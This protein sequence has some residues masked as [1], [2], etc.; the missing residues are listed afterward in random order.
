[1]RWPPPAKQGEV[2][3]HFFD[4]FTLA[5][6]ALGVAY[7]W[8]GFGFGLALL[9]GILWEAAENPIKAYLPKLFPHAT[10][11]TMANMTGDV[12]AVGCGWFVWTL[13]R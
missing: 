12:M 9:L 2:N 4:R 5:H 6:L 10:A 1:M 11:D 7:A 3:Y 8:L 13:L